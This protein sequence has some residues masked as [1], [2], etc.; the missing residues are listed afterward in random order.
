VESASSEAR[1]E[2]SGTFVGLA[3]RRKVK[4]Q[5]PASLLWD[6][7]SVPSHGSLVPEKPRKPASHHPWNERSMAKG[8]NRTKPAGGRPGKIEGASPRGNAWERI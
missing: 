7:R 6:D 1:G 4:A 2:L 8:K 5:Q 3:Q